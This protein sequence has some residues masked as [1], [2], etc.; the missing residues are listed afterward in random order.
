MGIVDWPYGSNCNRDK[1][2]QI[3][4][5]I[6][7]IILF[8]YIIAPILVAFISIII[9]INKFANVHC[10]NDMIT[11]TLISYLVTIIILFIFTLITYNI[12]S[13]NKSI[14][15]KNKEMLQLSLIIILSIIPW[16]YLYLY[17]SFIIPEKH[18]LSCSE[19]DN[20]LI[21]NY[22][23]MFSV[24]N[25]LWLFYSSFILFST[26]CTTLMLLCDKL[27]NNNS[28]NK[29]NNALLVNLV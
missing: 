22:V 29:Q 8:V 9:Y 4:N 12:N 16:I 15:M 25:G 20:K 19:G 10:G 6:V 28:Q 21:K 7:P 23:V 14:S 18:N 1:D 24:I 13:I 11:T 2:K 3:S 17:V 26:I 27:K 5:D